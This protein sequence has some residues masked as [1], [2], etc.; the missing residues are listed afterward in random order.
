M[1]RIFIILILFIANYALCQEVICEKHFTISPN[2][3][4]YMH[5][6]QLI[7]E[8]KISYDDLD[9][10]AAYKVL[11]VPEIKQIQPNAIS[12]NS[13]KEVTSDDNIFIEGSDN[14]LGI[15]EGTSIDKDY[16][17]TYPVIYKEKLYIPAL[18]QVKNISNICGQT[19]V[20]EVVND[21]LG[22]IATLNYF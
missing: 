15:R 9:L 19:E 12:D 1:K 18:I 13:T 22:L 17:Y 2:L 11:E 16:H 5:S 21:I 6:I 7:K 4:C 20:E 3:D 8:G 14:F 10:E